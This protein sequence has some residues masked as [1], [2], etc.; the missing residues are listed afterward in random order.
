MRRALCSVATMAFSMPSPAA[1]AKSGCIV[2]PP[3]CATGATTAQALECGAERCGEVRGGDLQAHVVLQLEST[4]REVGRADPHRLPVTDREFEMHQV[5]AALVH[6]RG[7]GEQ[8]RVRERVLRAAG[9]RV[10][11]HSTSM[12]ASGIER[13]AHADIARHQ[14]RQGREDVWMAQIVDGAVERV[15]R[16]VEKFHEPRGEMPIEPCALGMEVAVE[17]T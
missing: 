3:T 10:S 1:G 9:L 7:M 16:R 11:R 8:A 2:A 6:R 17:T 12:L 14:A 4:T 15:F 5:A 13:D